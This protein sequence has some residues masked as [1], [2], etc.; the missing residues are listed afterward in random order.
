MRCF[1]CKEL[2]SQQRL[3][4][5]LPYCGHSICE[6]CLRENY[7]NGEITCAQCH[8]VSRCENVDSFPTN[9]ALLNT[10]ISNPAHSSQVVVED[11]IRCERTNKKAEGKYL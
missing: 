8:T 2:F 4:K 6:V 1:Q 5:I 10:L 3:P 9:Y 7:N 11:E